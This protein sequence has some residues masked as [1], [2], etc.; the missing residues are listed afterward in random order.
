MTTRQQRFDHVTDAVTRLAVV[1]PALTPAARD[2]TDTAPSF[3]AAVERILLGLRDGMGAQSFDGPGGGAGGG[4]PIE[5]LLITPAGLTSDP[6]AK[7]LADL[8]TALR[9]LCDKIH[10]PSTCCTLMCQDARRIYH[11]VEAW[12]PHDANDRDRKR[13]EVTRANDPEAECAHH[14]AF[15]TFEP[16][17]RTTDGPG[18]LPHPLPLCRFCYDRLRSDGRLPTADRLQRLADGRGDRVRA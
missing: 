8:D 15:G 14:R 11:L 7:D 16:V 12:K 4:S 13:A 6:A 17:H 18:L 1:W 9:H 3:P 2:L 10:R 5:R